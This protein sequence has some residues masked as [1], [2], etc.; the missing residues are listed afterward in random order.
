[1]KTSRYHWAIVVV[2]FV[3]GLMLAVQFRAQDQV[4]NDPTVERTEKLSEQIEQKKADVEALQAKV[5]AM[6]L[7]LEEAA[8]EPELKALQREL[9]A[10]GILAGTTPVTGPGLEVTLKDSDIVLQPGQQQNP[11][12]YVLHDEDVL[13]V[14]NELKAAGAEVLAINDQRLIATSE[15]R[16]IGPVILV[17][18]NKRL[19]PPYVITAI[20]NPDTLYNSLYMKNGVVDSLKVWGIQV[21]AKKMKEVTIPGYDGVITHNGVRGEERT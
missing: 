10:A 9:T 12:L 7:Q 19:A 15:I 21:N 1:M 2:A 4:V 11:N 3:F 13:K 17:N 18:D 16:C 5:D 20:G 8:D 14:L 6:R